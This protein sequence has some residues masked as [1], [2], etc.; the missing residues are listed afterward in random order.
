MQ[1]AAARAAT[2]D[3]SAGWSSCCRKEC[4]SHNK[5]LDVPFELSI[6]AMQV[7]ADASTMPNH[8]KTCLP[9]DTKS[10]KV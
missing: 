10:G 7:H 6:T 4:K 2:E 3:H 1:H 9:A 5:V 8:R